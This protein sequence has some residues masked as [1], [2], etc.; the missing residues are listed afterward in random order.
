MN[1]NKFQ[2]KFKIS[3]PIIKNEI[4]NYIRYLNVKI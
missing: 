4:N 3:L 1:V 2:K